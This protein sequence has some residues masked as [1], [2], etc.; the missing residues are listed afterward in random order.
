M[1]VL[2]DIER[3]TVA[4][5]SIPRNVSNLA[6]ELRVDPFAPS[7][8]DSEVNDR[9]QELAKQGLVVSL[10]DGRDLSP[11]ELAHKANS[12]KQTYSMPD[13]KAKIFERRL[14]APHR[15][16]RLD[17][18]M[19]MFTQ[20]G[21]DALHAPLPG[22]GE[23]LGTVA[24]ANLI[25]QEFKRVK[26][27]NPKS[28]TAETGQILL[29]E[30]YAAWL[31]EV[32]KDWKE[33]NKTD[34][35]PHALRGPVGGGAGYNDATELLILDAENGKSSYTETAPWYMAL[36]TVAVTDADTGSTL[37]EAN[38]TGYARKSVAAADM[39]SAASGAATNAN[40]IIFAACTGGT[41]AVIGFAKCAASTAGRA[42]KHGTC[43]TV[44]ISSTQTPAQFAVGAFTTSLD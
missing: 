19:W 40:A 15:A 24:L 39:N 31:K 35:L 29:S 30:E 5:L 26:D 21:F 2:T 13:E 22:A 44:N 17:G 6:H 18:E 42:I 28:E 12:N 23:P 7:L 43:S 33:R 3:R 4:N 9:L 14:A 41:S 1:N 36:V 8:S 37:T 34:K 27:V 25:Q 32:Q 20:E 11:G 10:G 16:W 38:Y